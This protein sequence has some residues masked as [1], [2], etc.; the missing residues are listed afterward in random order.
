MTEVRIKLTKEMALEYHL[1]GKI[2]L[3]LLKPLRNDIDLSLAYTPGVAEACRL[4][5]TDPDSAFTHTAKGNTVAVVTDGTAVLGLGDIGAAASIPVMEGKAVLFKAFADIDAWPVPLIAVRQQ[6][7][8]GRSD[9]DAFVDTVARLAVMYGGINIEDVA[10][11]E[12]FEIEDRL[13]DMLDIPVFHDD[14][15]GTA[16]ISLAGLKNYLLLTGKHMADIK[17]V[18]NGGGAAGIRI[19]ELFRHAGA[20]NI[21][22]CDSKGVIHGERSDLTAQ[23]VQFARDTPCRSLAEVIRGADVF[24]GVSQP[25]LVTGEMVR[26]MAP[27]PAIFAMANPEP[28]IR[29]EEVKIARNDAWIATGRSDY[30]NQINNVLGFPFIFRGALDVR[31]MDITL[32][33][34]IACSEALA[35]LAREEVPEY[36]RNAYGGIDLTFG[37][38]YMIPKPFDRRV[39]VRA[40]S[41]VAESA[42]KDGAARKIID[43]GEYTRALEKKVEKMWMK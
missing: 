23:K 35:E 17:I 27:E 14:Q 26:S 6:G 13:R 1:G 20:R 42:I 43:I 28:E 37:R 38:E 12:C 15:H 40:S 39:F 32:N 8:T 9:P 36:V 4:I 16:I 18:I 7:L 11:P 5:E 3:G 10:A 29:P 41:A 2:G 19:G 24:I 22:M 30:P 31:A 25:R 34:K 33:M 21:F